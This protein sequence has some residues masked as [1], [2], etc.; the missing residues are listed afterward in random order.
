MPFI[1][2]SKRKKYFGM[3]DLTRHIRPKEK[4]PDKPKMR[5]ILQNTWPILLKIVKVVKNRE[6]PR[7]GQN[8]DN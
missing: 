3:A 1:I 6:R 8:R 2:A 7:N 5:D 4:I